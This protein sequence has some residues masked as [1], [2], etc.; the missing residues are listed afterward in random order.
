MKAFF[1]LK[2]F[3]N[4]S[5]SKKHDIWLDIREF[6]I[7]ISILPLDDAYIIYQKKPSAEV[8]QLSWSN[9]W[10]LTAPV[11]MDNKHWIKRMWILFNYFGI[12]GI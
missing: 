12:M 4:H 10:L 2:N 5:F 1:G 7:E 8:S 3:L 11:A 6:W 9:E